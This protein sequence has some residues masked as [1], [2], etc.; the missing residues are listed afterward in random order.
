MI[1]KRL[2]VQD[3]L[4]QRMF[5]GFVTWPTTETEYK[6]WVHW[7]SFP[8]IIK[9]KESVRPIYYFNKNIFLKR[10]YGMFVCA[11]QNK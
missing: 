2:T 3:L 11:N 9:K 7:E 10:F 1:L 5:P 6:S 8:A 4:L